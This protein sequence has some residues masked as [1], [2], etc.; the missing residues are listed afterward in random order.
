MPVPT[1]GDL[2]DVKRYLDNYR[3]PRD[4]RGVIQPNVTGLSP[5]AGGMGSFH[6]PEEEYERFLENIAAFVFYKNV[7]LGLVE[8]PYT[9]EGGQVYTPMKIDLDFRFPPEAPFI[10]DD[11]K[12]VR[13]YDDKMIQAFVQIV[14]EETVKGSSFAE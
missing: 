10:G 1:V 14:W 11:A 6:I 9:D 13:Q 3:I 5:V 8:R 12:P 7:P 2:D 4:K